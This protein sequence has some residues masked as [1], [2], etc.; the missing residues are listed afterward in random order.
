MKITIEIDV[1]GDAQ[2]AR[3]HHRQIRVA[4]CRALEDLIRFDRET[5]V[6]PIEGRDYV[7][8]GTLNCV[9]EREV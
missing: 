3:L 9:V 6:Q 8:A 1:A 5:L 4:V 7:F 2:Q